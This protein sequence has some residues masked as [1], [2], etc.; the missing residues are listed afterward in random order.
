MRKG[1]ESHRIGVIKNHSAEH[2]TST[3]RVQ[4]QCYILPY[5]WWHNGWARMFVVWD[6]F[7]ELNE[8]MISGGLCV[9]A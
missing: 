9:L 1:I 2:S 5:I 8:R 7:T 4:V 6:N 3:V